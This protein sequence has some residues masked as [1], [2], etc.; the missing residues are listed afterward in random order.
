[1]EAI[2]YLSVPRSFRGVRDYALVKWG[3][4]SFFLEGRIVR[5][6]SPTTL[7]AYVEIDI[8]GNTVKKVFKRDGK[9]LKTYRDVF[10]TFV[11]LSFSS[12]E[13]AFMD[14]PPAERRK[15]FDWALSLLDGRYYM[16]LIK[17]RKFLAEKKAALR[18]GVD[19]TPINRAMLPHVEYIVSRRREF[20]ERIN[21]GVRYSF[22]PYTFAMRY[23][24][25]VERAEDL[26]KLGKRELEVGIPLFGPHRDRYDILLEGKPVRFFASEGQKRRIHLGIVLFVRDLLEE[27][28]EDPPVMVL[29]EPLVYLDREGS[30]G[31][32]NSLKGQVFLSS[33]HRPKV[34]VPWNEI[35]LT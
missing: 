22:V 35:D 29:D 26:P 17:Y 18:S 1:L 12:R 21:L 7:T 11:V 14:G 6:G 13:H 24:P 9:T 16:H 25:S 23:R 31:V 28:L 15:F 30:E 27:K 8:R 3:E 33:T 10:N 34:E 32:L 4:S 19:P 20:V 2:A 5:L